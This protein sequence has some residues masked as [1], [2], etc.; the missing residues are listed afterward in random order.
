MTIDIDWTQIIIAL[1]QFML[2]PVLLWVAKQA[3]V[4]FKTRT[5]T[6]VNEDA[7][8]RALHF[9]DLAATAIQTA[10]A[11]TG[12]TFVDSIKGTTGWDSATMQK[13]FIQSRDRAIQIMGE[14]VYYGLS[15][16]VGDVNA[17]ITAQIEATV[18]NTRYTQLSEVV[19]SVKAD[20]PGA[21]TETETEEGG[22]N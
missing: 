9:L 20:E 17:W 3:V 7:R 2:V 4:Y 14:A 11:E 1:I 18:R 22:A 5:N 6:L 21:E 19:E 16:A 10:V 8:A 15:E 13:A 12:Q